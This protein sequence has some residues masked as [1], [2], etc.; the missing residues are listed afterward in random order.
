MGPT[1]RLDLP[2]NEQVVTRRPRNP[3]PPPPAPPAP[4]PPPPGGVLVPFVGGF[5]PPPPLPVRLLLAIGCSLPRQPTAA[6]RPPRRGCTAAALPAHRCAADTAS[7]VHP[8][9]NDDNL[10]KPYDG[11]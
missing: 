7:K 5:V 1:S 2:Q 3:P 9:T 8:T 10:M 11:D 6:V 4:P